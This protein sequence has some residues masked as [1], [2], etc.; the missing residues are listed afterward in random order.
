M[1]Q[2]ARARGRRSFQEGRGPAL[3]AALQHCAIER[4]EKE[5]KT[6]LHAQTCV[7][8]AICTQQGDTYN[9]TI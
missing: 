3:A 9:K 6:V 7:R 2:P 4:Q 5:S 1:E 8:S